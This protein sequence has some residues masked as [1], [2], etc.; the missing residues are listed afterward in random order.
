[1]R[2]D[3]HIV[4]RHRFLGLVAWCGVA[5]GASSSPVAAQEESAGS[6]KAVE[7]VGLTR[8]SE[9]YAAEIAGVEAGDPLDPA[10]LDEAVNRLLRTGRFL[11]VRYSVTEEADG[12]RVTF[13]VTEPQVLSAVRFEGNAQFSDRR[14]SEQ[15]AQQ[16][17]ERVDPFAVRM[18]LES[19]EAMYREAGYNDVV[20]T[21]DREQLD[22]AGELVY[23][24]EEGK[25][26]RIREI[27]FE[28]VTAFSARTLKRQ[29]EAKPAL[30][31]FRAGAFDRDRVESD[32]A[33]LRNYYRD[34]GYLDASV[35]YRVDVS[36]TGVDL[37]LVFIIE[38]GTCYKIEDIQF[39]G[40]TV[41]SAE[42]L[43][44]VMVSRVGETVKRPQVDR[45]VGAIR[46]RYWELGYIYVV[47]RAVRVFSQTPG[48]VRITVLIE[49]GEQ[50]RVGRVV[51]R[52][53]ARTKDKVV[54]RAL[55]LYPPDDL[56]DLTEA[57]EAERRLRETP[58]FS[59]ARV[60]PVGDA[61]GVRD[62][63]IDVA[64][65]EKSGDFLFGLGVTSNSGIVGTVILDLQ[66]FD[67]FDWPRSWEEL[68]RFRSFF[69]AGQRLRLELQ[70]GGDVN[71][72]RI[73][74]TEPYL[75]DK[76]IRFDWSTYLFERGR[77]G[78]NERRVGTTISLG[79]RFERGQLRG[80][81]GE[82]ALRLESVNVDDID[83]FASGEIRDDEGSNLM[84]S[85]KATM[86]RDRTDSR[87]LPSSGDRLR[88]GYEQY[89]ILG[90]DHV[91]GKV[92]ARYQWYK[93][94]KTDLLDRKSVLQLRAQG[95]AIIGNAP[96]FERFFAGGT[97]SIRGFE[98]RGVGERDGI[99]ENNIGGD[100]LVLLGAEYSYPLYG[101][102]LRGHVFM[103]TG[104]V[105]SGMYR[106]SI[107]TGVRFTINVL[108]PVP[109]EFNLA[110]PILS[111]SDDDEQV[112]SFLVGSL[113]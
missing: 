23:T 112:F 88:I 45:D 104:T 36:E 77:D 32:V 47:A 98:F 14:L 3:V 84:T 75:L 1:M 38:E 73:D 64:E 21:Y 105:G 8:S 109:L 53:N 76:P 27:L 103:D 29:I 67:L 4:G 19:I 9:V 86:V 51:V 48:F 83:L 95:G 56:L 31:V 6:I 30:W 41:F 44:Q 35:S 60:L 90:G 61:P 113:F 65:S 58:I 33:R 59:S 78:Y 110:V 50:Y 17:G 13:T 42:E 49:E 71:R 22:R 7:F 89:G 16:V 34:Q 100:Y 24:I 69:G 80:W 93:T 37:T 18:G 2:K 79:K 102:N 40:H 43:A 12:V 74:F 91:F 55:N 39:Q 96:V 94:I 87:L 68:F 101:D 66:N 111:D 108:G 97:G 63:I 28:G 72:F 26:V 92:T 57:R 15:V 25:R 99:D 11:S 107:G 52:G 10:G 85:V 46:D 82:L 5:I 70:P 62:L 54:R 81:S 20:V 106:A